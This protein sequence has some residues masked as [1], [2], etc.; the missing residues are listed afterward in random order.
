[1]HSSGL[2]Y[3]TPQLFMTIW[4]KYFQHSFLGASSFVFSYTLKWGF[5]IELIDIL[6]FHSLLPRVITDF[7][8]LCL[9]GSFGPIFYRFWVMWEHHNR[10]LLG[11]LLQ[12]LWYLHLLMIFFP[13]NNLQKVWGKRER[14]R[15]RKLKGSLLIKC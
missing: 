6:I 11:E 10:L 15:N 14:K 8:V 5:K 7:D 1:M 13:I 4:E 12:A 9:Q 3:S 2:A